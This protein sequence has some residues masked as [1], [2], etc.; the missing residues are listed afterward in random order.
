M[1]L[2]NEINIAPEQGDVVNDAELNIDLDTGGGGDDVG[3]G[4]AQ[5]QTEE[6]EPTIKELMD[7]VKSQGKEITK[8]NNRTQY[9]QRKLDRSNRVQKLDPAKAKPVSEDFETHDE[10]VEALTDWKVDQTERAKVEKQTA[11]QSKEQEADFFAVIDAGSDR[12]ADF[13]EVARKQPA[14]GGPEITPAMLEAMMESDDPVE[15]A[16]Y[17]GNNVEES[18]K[19]ARMSPVGA[20]RAL[21][22]IEERFS[23]GGAQ[24]PKPTPQK[25]KTKDITPSSP[26]TGKTIPDKD[27]SKM[28]TDDF[29]NSRNKRDGVE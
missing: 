5:P 15:L 11:N 25:T 17:L 28:S 21:G 20:A 18:K 22:K 24:N 14:D 8:A 29:M 3:E 12:Y 4:E 23:A 2:E 13:D 19:I 10:Y 27:L 26:I 6:K 1:S 7:L 16:Y 9:L